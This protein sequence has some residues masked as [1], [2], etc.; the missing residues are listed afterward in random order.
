LGVSNSVENLEL[1]LSKRFKILELSRIIATWF[2]NWHEKSEA[3]KR[4]KGLALAGIILTGFLKR[5]EKF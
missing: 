2:Y 1:K 4:L 3:G 5:Y